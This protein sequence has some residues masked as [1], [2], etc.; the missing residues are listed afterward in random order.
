MLKFK[1]KYIILGF[2]T[3]TIFSL[4]NILLVQFNLLY[5]SK[6]QQDILLKKENLISNN[7]YSEE[8]SI[9][10]QPQKENYVWKII[11]P[12]INLEQEINQGTSQEVIAKA[13]GHFEHTPT[14]Y[15]NVGLAAHNSGKDNGF[16]KD[17]TKLKIGDEII[18]MS[19]Y[20]SKRY[21]IDLIKQIEETDWTYLENTQSNK[22]TLITCVK[23]M[24]NRRLCVQGTES[25]IN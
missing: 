19:E 24:P 11:I 18:Y 22:I 14:L 21:Q 23:N 17:L 6:Q 25:I 8:N 4:I 15:G 3:I 10:N 1:Y 12:K 5:Q 2:I 20:G 9:S 7:L 13:I 16:F